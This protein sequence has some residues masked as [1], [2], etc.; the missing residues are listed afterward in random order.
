MPRCCRTLA[1]GEIKR[2]R[3]KERERVR[4]REGFAEGI[5]GARVQYALALLSTIR[6]G[7]EKA[8]L[9]RAEPSDAESRTEKRA[10][11]ESSLRRPRTWIPVL[12]RARIGTP[13]AV[14]RARFVSAASDREV[15]RSRDPTLALD[16]LPSTRGDQGKRED[17]IVT[18]F[19]R[20][21]FARGN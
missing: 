2:E 6:R 11:P 10:A 14:C 18:S 8:E 21:P 9:A 3:A 17:T 1:G 4:A 19:N 12:S 15:S 20:H 16:R 7:G 13:Q 5:G